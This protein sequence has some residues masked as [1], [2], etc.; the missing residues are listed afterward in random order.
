MGQMTE[1]VGAPIRCMNVKTKGL[2]KRAIC[3]GRRRKNEDRRGERRALSSELGIAGIGVAAETQWGLG[4][5]METACGKRM[6]R[7]RNDAQRPEQPDQV[8]DWNSHPGK[9]S[10]LEMRG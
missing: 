1:G 6:T 9:I 5:A 3:K 8:T 7:V 10:C 4:W 2:R